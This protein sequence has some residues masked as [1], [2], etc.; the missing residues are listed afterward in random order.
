[1][2]RESQEKILDYA[3]VVPSH[4]AS[5]VDHGH[6][7]GRQ[8]GRILGSDAG[9]VQVE[10]FADVEVGTLAGDVHRRTT[11]SVAKRAQIYALRN[12]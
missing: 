3:E 2:V 10:A 7:K 9:A 12:A 6:V 5:F 11:F 1:M 4:G 8:P